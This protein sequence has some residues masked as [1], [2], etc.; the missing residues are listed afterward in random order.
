MRG[1]EGAMEAVLLPTQ[2]VVPRAGP[3]TTEALV[4][5]CRAYDKDSVRYRA[6]LAELRSRW[7]TPT[8]FM[9]DV[10]ARLHVP[11]PFS[12]DLCAEEETSAGKVYLG[13]GSPLGE[14]G[15][16]CPMPKGVRTIWC[17]PPWS[18]CD[19]WVDRCISIFES[20]RVLVALCLPAYCDNLWW[21][22]LVDLERKGRALRFEVLGRV[23]YELHP[24]VVEAGLMSASSSSTE[25][26]VLWILN[27]RRRRRWID[28]TTID[29]RGRTSPRR[30]V[31]PA[32]CQFWGP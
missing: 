13:P 22:R 26:T 9:L 21:H 24:L 11:F 12:L 30:V 18:N 31:L 15:L 28:R 8:W 6:S 17:N 20:S 19:P 25:R 29:A 27:P 16:L 3:A 2:D 14:D 7:I 32:Q 1:A 23:N 10:A 5:V 4:R